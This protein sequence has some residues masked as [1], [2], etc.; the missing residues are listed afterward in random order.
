LLRGIFLSYFVKDLTITIFIFIN[1]F[2]IVVFKGGAVLD[3]N[4]TKC[5]AWLRNTV[6]AAP[7]HRHIF[8][9]PPPGGVAEN[10]KSLGR[11]KAK[12]PIMVK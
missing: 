4:L 8:G 3:K 12:K 5:G 6:L 11:A 9:G 2:S 1:I 7:L 10:P